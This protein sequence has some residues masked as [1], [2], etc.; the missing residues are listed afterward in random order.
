MDFEIPYS[1]NALVDGMR[2]AR[3][4]QI[5]ACAANLFLQNGLEQVKMV[6]IAG[7]AGVGVATLYRHFSTKTSIAVCAAT[8][9]W[10]QFNLMIR[11]LVESDAFLACN[12]LSRLRFLLEEYKNAYLAYGDFVFFLDTFDHMVVNQ[13]I[14]REELEEYGREVDS[15]YLIFADA[16]ALGRSD[17][18]ILREVEFRPFYLALAHALIGVAQKLRRGEIIP[19]DD[20]SNAQ[21]ELQCIIDMAMWSLAS[22]DSKEEQAANGKRR[23]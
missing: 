16:Y 11:E 7:S 17:G 6:D 19:S 14:R 18:S 12:G 13:Q 3:D 10:R 8:L 15:F 1:Q 20:F 4:N 22:A 9:M 2:D 23:G 5:I 21:L